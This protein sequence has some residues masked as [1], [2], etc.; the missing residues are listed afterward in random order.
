MTTALK[1]SI[2][3]SGFFCALI[4]FALPSKADSI[5][6]YT[7][8]PYEV[9]PVSSAGYTAADH[10]TAT[11]DLVD[12]LL[13]N[14]SYNWS[15]ALIASG[16]ATDT[17]AS[18]T[19]S[20]GLLAL[21]PPNAY[22]IQI[23]TGA[24]GQIAE[25]YM[26]GCDTDVVGTPCAGNHNN[27]DS[28]FGLYVPEGWDQTV[29]PGGQILAYVDGNPGTWTASSAVPEPSSIVLLGAGLV[30]ALGAMKRKLLG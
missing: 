2:Q 8:N 21:D 24:Q 27:I 1:S 13:A 29:T 17:L 10:I 11:L 23:V 19:I 15:T 28:M 16:S 4:L 6:T 7:G 12:P 9:F 26:A 5:Y 25:W 18:F 22:N 14:Q 20:D 30:G 3:V